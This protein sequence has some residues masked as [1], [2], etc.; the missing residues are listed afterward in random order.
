MYKCM[1]CGHEFAS[2]KSGLI[3][4]PKCAYKVIMKLRPKVVKEIKAR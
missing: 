3:Q 4:C 1:H 2:I